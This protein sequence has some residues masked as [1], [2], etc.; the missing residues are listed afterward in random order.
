MIT[1][2][3]NSSITNTESSLALPQYL[4]V[5]RGLV[6]GASV[7]NIYGYQPSVGTTFI[8]VSYTHLTLPTQRI[9]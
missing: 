3:P 4:Q 6:T 8:P 9:V 7:V 5:A 2:Y 1:V